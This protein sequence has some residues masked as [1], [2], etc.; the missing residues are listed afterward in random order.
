MEKIKIIFKMEGG[1]WENQEKG[2]RLEAWKKAYCFVC[3]DPFSFI[4]FTH[5][6]T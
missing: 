4:L 1:S 3:F 2:C 5:T 6:N